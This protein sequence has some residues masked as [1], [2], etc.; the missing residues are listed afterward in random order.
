MK[1]VA[2]PI[3]A[4]SWSNKNGDIRPLRFKFEDEDFSE[5]VRVDR[6]VKI[7]KTQRAGENAFVFTCESAIAG[8]RRLY[9]LRYTLSNCTWVLYKF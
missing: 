5:I 1:L 2:R 6:I 7:E 8:I 4:I 9:E 3:D